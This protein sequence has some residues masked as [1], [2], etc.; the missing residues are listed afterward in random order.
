MRL[1]CD[2]ELTDD[3][4]RTLPRRLWDAGQR[5]VDRTAYDIERWAKM[6]APVDT[7][8]LRNSIHTI[9]KGSSGYDKALGRAERADAK[10]HAGQRRSAETGRWMDVAGMMLE[11][12][13]GA[14]FLSA[15]VAVGAEYGVYVEYGTVNQAA[16]P[17]LEPAVEGV[18][19]VWERGL[20]ELFEDA[21]GGAAAG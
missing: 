3:R 12:T 18:R 13:S 19:P 6:L 9:T 20:E 10:R 2:V 7:G 11:E 4:L 17:Y 16:Q 15:I 21:I 8:F 14:G 5:L 1:T